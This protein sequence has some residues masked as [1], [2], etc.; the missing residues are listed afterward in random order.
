MGLF[1]LTVSYAGQCLDIT[2]I[3][4]WRAECLRTSTLTRVRLRRA[5]RHTYLRGRLS[6]P[7]FAYI[8]QL[9][10]CQGSAEER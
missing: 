8:G 2:S 10:I 4:A 9:V 6:Q 1:F 7:P 3:E 5:A